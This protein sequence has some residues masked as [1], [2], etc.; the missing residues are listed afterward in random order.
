MNGR[1]YGVVVGYY[2]DSPLKGIAVSLA[3]ELGY[4]DRT[5]TAVWLF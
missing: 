2:P 3:P 1:P 4:M 5:F